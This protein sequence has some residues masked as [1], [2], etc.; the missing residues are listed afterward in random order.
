[1]ARYSLQFLSANRDCIL[2]GVLFWLAQSQI[3]LV[4]CCSRITVQ[5]SFIGLTLCDDHQCV[6]PMSSTV[7]NTHVFY[8]IDIYR[9]THLSVTVNAS[10]ITDVEMKSVWRILNKFIIFVLQ[11][12]CWIAQ[13]KSRNKLFMFS[14]AFDAFY[15]IINFASESTRSSFFFRLVSWF[16]GRQTQGGVLLRQSYNTALRSPSPR[17]YSH[18]HQQSIQACKLYLLL[19]CS[20]NLIMFEETVQ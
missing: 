6:G 4:S 13:F 8:I 20:V 15:L 9:H 2:G 7:K 14:T 10:V 17:W 5:T 19:L 3:W 1:M 11:T 12:N 18:H 16:C